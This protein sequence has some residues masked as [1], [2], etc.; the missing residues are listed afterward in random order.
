MATAA[1]RSRGWSGPARI[2]I[3]AIILI[4]IL[5]LFVFPTR[6]FL[7]QRGAVDDAR[8][9]VQVMHEQNER[10]AAEAK[11]LQTPAEIQRMAREQYHYVYPG[12]Q[13]YSVI[14]APAPTTST[15]TP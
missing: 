9:D 15:T 12:E 6:S 11:R 13:A 3:I 7:A 1:H 10:L 2:A 4:A 5:F 8:H 14:P